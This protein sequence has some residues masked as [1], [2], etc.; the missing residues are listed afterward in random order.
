[1]TGVVFYLVN[2]IK[3]KHI[4]LKTLQKLPLSE[5][6]PK[7]RLYS[8]PLQFCSKKYLDPLKSRQLGRICWIVLFKRHFWWSLIGVIF[9]NQGGSFYFY[10]WIRQRSLKSHLQ[11][12]R[13]CQLPKLKT[14]WNW[15]FKTWHQS[16]LRRFW[17]VSEFKISLW[18]VRSATLVL[19]PTLY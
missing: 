14:Q 17:S 5:F 2:S 9:L 19:K 16:E 11:K 8:E 4:T 13:L 7:V 6:K 12:W 1:M 3:P 10:E 15:L 18:S